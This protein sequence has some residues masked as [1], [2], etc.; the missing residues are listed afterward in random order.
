MLQAYGE[1]I[2]QEQLLDRP[3]S[4]IGKANL[5]HRRLADQHRL[6]AG[7]A[8]FEFWPRKARDRAASRG[9]AYRGPGPQVAFAIG[10]Q[11][12][13]DALFGSRFENAEV[14]DQTVGRSFGSRFA[15]DVTRAG[16]DFLLDAHLSD[17][18]LADVSHDDLMRSR[19]A[20]DRGFR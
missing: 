5:E 8:D 11:I 14:P 4:R 16:R 6:R 3:G 20:D 7:H 9:I 10:L 19:L 18:R 15:S 2:A 1:S 13:L 12:G 17:G